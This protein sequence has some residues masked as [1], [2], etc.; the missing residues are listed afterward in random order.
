MARRSQ[1]SPPRIQRSVLCDLICVLVSLGSNAVTTD[2]VNCLCWNVVSDVDSQCE[3]GILSVVCDC[4]AVTVEVR[5]CSRLWR[6]E[7]A[8]G[9]G[10]ANVLTPHTSQSQVSL[11]TVIFTRQTQAK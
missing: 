3:E 2:R 8:H 10:G 11:E 6:C 4:R 5:T 9:C 1:R 7:R